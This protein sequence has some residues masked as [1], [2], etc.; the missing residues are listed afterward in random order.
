VFQ[1]SGPRSG[2]SLRKRLVAAAAA[3][4]AIGLALTGCSNLAPKTST[5]G[6]AVVVIPALATQM[7]FDTSFALTAGYF[8]TSDELFSDLIT[9]KYV[10]GA[11]KNTQDQD[12]YN[13]TGVLAKNYKISSDGL[14]YTFNLR[15][16]VKSVHGN[17]LTADDVVWSF[18]RKFKA[19]TSIVPYVTQPAITSADQFTAPSKYVVKVTIA[20]KQYGFTLLSNLADIVGQ[21]YDAKF[22]KKHVTAA[23]PWA[24]KFSS[25]RYD[26]GFGPYRVQSVT[27]GSEMVLTSNKGY[28]L[29]APKI[30]KIIQRVVPDAGN[31]AQALKTGSA[32]VALGLLP[33]DLDALRS[34]KSVLVPTKA[35]NGYIALSLNM[36]TGPFKDIAVRKAFAD[37][38]DYKHIISEV[39]HGLAK[40]KNNMLDA[41]APGYDGSGLP[42]YSYDAAKAKSIL[43]AAGYT[44]NVAV[45]ITVD[46]GTQALVD[47]AVAI[48]SSA[49]AAGFDVT[50]NAVPTAQAGQLGSSGQTQAA[51]FQGEA[52]AVTPGYQLTL[53]TT[54]GGSSNYGQYDDP[55]FEK[56]LTAANDLPDPLSKAGGTAYN[57]AEKRWLGDQ[58]ASIFIGTPPSDSAVSTTLSGWTWR[59]DHAVDLSV[60]SV[61]K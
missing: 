10:K 2:K 40:K 5:G 32:Q 46:S 15:Q 26:F 43:A 55:T 39:Y 41:S 58:L 31:R 29:G 52:L 12:L 23:D 60:L 47:S 16:G 28:A 50:V 33:A 24:T 25:G 51:L 54:P 3:T 49:A 9:Q 6:T 20:K 21:I 7:S 59:V 4:V 48:K 27:A 34:D 19:A 45:S 13:F 11:Q 56:L 30:T 35:R 61:T 8:D 1:N 57:A 38:I 17:E 42:D 44:K 18:Q 36:K 37:A 22:L 14:T 53:Q